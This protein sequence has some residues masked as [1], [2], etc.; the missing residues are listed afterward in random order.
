MPEFII[1]ICGITRLEDALASLNAGADCLG[2]IRWPQSPRYRP[3]EECAELIHAIRAKT[4][5]P[6]QAVGVF[7][8][9]P[10]AEVNAEI[11]CAGFDR[12]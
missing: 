2:F 1:K 7:V 8:D 3:L 5:K 4:P 11:A 9:A 6:F 12:V 10:A